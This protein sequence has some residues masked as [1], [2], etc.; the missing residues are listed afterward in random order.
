MGPIWGSEEYFTMYKIDGKTFLNIQEQVQKNKA[1]IAAYK[2]LQFTL[3]NFGITVL[4]KVNAETD[5]PED[6]YEYGDAYLVGTEEP[7]DLYIYTRTDDPDVGEFINIGPISVVGPQG[8][9]GE[10][11]EQGPRGL[12]G[13]TGPAGATGATGA[14]GAK[15]E[16]GDPGE[17]GPQGIQGI[18]GDPGQS[19]MIMGEITSTAQLPDPAETPRNYAYVL[20]DG[21]ISTPNQLYYITGDVGDEVW[22]HA[23]FAGTGTT[24][25]VNGTPVSTWTPDNI[26][27]LPYVSYNIVSTSFQI[28]QS[29]VD[30]LTATPHPS[31][32]DTNTGRLY[33]YTGSSNNNTAYS[34]YLCEGAVTY[35]LKLDTTTRYFNIYTTQLQLRLAST[36]STDTLSYVIGFNASGNL[37]KGTP[38]GVTSFGAATGAI[39]VNDENMVMDSNEANAQ[40]KSWYRLW[41]TDSAETAEWSQ[42][43]NILSTC[44]I[45]LGSPSGSLNEP[46]DLKCSL[47]TDGNGNYDLWIRVKLMNI[48]INNS[49]LTFNA[50]PANFHA[51]T[52]GSQSGDKQYYFAP[53]DLYRGTQY[54]IIPGLYPSLDGMTFATIVNENSPY[55]SSSKICMV[56]L[57]YSSTVHGFRWLGG[58]GVIY[59]NTT[60]A[61]DTASNSVLIRYS[62]VGRTFRELDDLDP[63]WKTAT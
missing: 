40:L 25:I 55:I 44:P 10:P 58:N 21:D 9:Q 60:S 54:S 26:Q 43:T 13:E 4:G 39:T 31:I 56:P 19:F 11:G 3:N 27:E 30:I 45:D 6:T 35:E 20:D 48:A 16:K 51:Y 49:Y 29:L 15:G 18:Q 5:I 57:A 17:T 33:I 46:T 63:N 23:T 59:V 22:S 32:L 34:W 38:G 28:D 36:M 41:R 2:N 24:V 12:T 42:T 8:P 61:P 62:Y 53:R 50:G 37:R 52:S 14:T 47:Y 1:D 7:Y